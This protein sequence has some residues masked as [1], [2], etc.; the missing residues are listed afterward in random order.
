MSTTTA[1][2]EI[3]RVD[4][5]DKRPKPGMAQCSLTSE[6]SSA[7]TKNFD[8]KMDMENVDLS[9]RDEESDT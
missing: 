5:A 8:H 4:N 7:Q 1:E 3:G 9:R 6:E 2:P